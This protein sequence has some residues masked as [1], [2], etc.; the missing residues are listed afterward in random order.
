MIFKVSFQLQIKHR[1]Y[2]KNNC[3]A[4]ADFKG[5]ACKYAIEIL[6]ITNFFLFSYLIV[7]CCL[8][9]KFAS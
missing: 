3:S 6:C 4:Y 8:S 9:L 7:K 5:A 2:L 1:S